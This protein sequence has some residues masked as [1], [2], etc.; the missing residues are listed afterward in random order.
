[1]I[2]RIAGKSKQNNLEKSVFLPYKP[3]EEEKDEND[4]KIKQQINRAQIS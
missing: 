3:K 2:L 1:M 4:D